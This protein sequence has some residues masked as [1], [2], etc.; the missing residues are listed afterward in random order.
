MDR[1]LLNLLSLLIG[2]AGIF[3]A[4]TK[5]SVPEVNQSFFGTNPFLIKSDAI[6]KVTTWAFTLLALLALA[7]QVWAEVWGGTLP[8]RSYSVPQ[9]V[10]ASLTA[11]AV[12]IG[13]LMVIAKVSARIARKTWEPELVRLQR[14]L[15]QNALEMVENDGWSLQHI[16]ANEHQHPEADTIRI[17]NLENVEHN[18]RQ[19]ERLFDVSNTAGAQ[20]ERLRR[21]EQIF[22]KHVAV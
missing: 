4:L 10:G 13:V 15:F 19:L 6:E 21:I 7:L 20:I 8:E 9:Y 18:I 12:L 14:E 3:S 11:V 2:G 17:R 16:R 22:R 5:Y 1:T